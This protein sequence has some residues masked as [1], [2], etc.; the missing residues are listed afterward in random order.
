MIMYNDTLYCAD[1][2]DNVTPMEVDGQPQDEDQAPGLVIVEF[3]SA[4]V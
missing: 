2:R 3:D 1:E 4:D